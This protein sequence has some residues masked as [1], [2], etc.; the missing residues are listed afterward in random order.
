M[1][2]LMKFYREDDAILAV[3]LESV[4][5]VNGDLNCYSYVGQHSTAT[6]D[7]LEGLDY[8]NNQEAEEMIL[9]LETNYDY[10]I[11]NKNYE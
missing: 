8:A 9:H 6:E 11:I 5:L 3:F 4:N 2:V 10:E 7:Y 1:K